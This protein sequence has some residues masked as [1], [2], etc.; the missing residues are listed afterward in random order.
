[1]DWKGKT[2]FVTGAVSGL[3]FGIARAYS[4][5]GMRLALGYRNEAYR[6]DAERWFADNAA[7]CRCS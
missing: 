6:A 4:N 1:M 2:A 3:G 7:K 5:A